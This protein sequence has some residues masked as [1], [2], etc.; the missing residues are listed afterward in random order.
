MHSRFYQWCQWCANIVE[1]STFGAGVMPLVPV[2]MPVILLARLMVLLV[3]FVSQWYHW[4]ASGTIGATGGIASLAN[5]GTPNRAIIF[6]LSKNMTHA[7][8]MIHSPKCLP[9]LHPYTPLL[10]ILE[11][12]LAGYITWK[13]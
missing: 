1:G 11:L 3:P 5:W 13:C 6:D 10:C 12:G 9:V 8:M 4:W 7:Q 2:V